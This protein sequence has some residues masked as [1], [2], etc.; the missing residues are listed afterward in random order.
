M[1][2]DTPTPEEAKASADAA[3][4]EAKAREKTL[5]A[6]IAAVALEK[7][8]T[9]EIRARLLALDEAADR[10]GKDKETQFTASARAREAAGLNQKL[11]EQE[12]ATLQK[13]MKIGAKMSQQEQSRYKL[14]KK[15]LANQAT[16][17][18]K[19]NSLIEGAGNLMEDK[20][21]GAVHIVAK[22]MESTLSDKF[23]MLSNSVS[24]LADKGFAK[25][26]TAA[27]DLIFQFDEVTKGF[28][29]QM[30][31]GAEYTNQI[32]S[33][34]KALNDYG[35]SLADAAEAQTQLATQFTDFTMLSISQREE[36]SANSAVLGQ[37]G[38]AQQD[39]ARGVQNSTKFFGQS[40]SAAVVT[41][42]ELMET[43]RA[44]GRSPAELSAEFAAAGSSLAKFGEQGVQAFKDL[45]RISKITGMEMNKVLSITNKFDTFEGAA[46][47]AGK[48]N[49]AM[50]GNMVNAM[51]MMMETDPAA[52][53]ETLRESIL[54]TV[55]SFDDMSYYQKQFYAESLGL[56]DVGD[57]AM[58][59]SGNM[60]SLAGATNQ[61]AAS[62][63]EEKENALQ[64]KTAKENLTI[65]MAKLAETFLPLVDS[66][67]KFASYLAQNEKLVRTLVI[68]LGLWK[69]VAIA[70][71]T[72]RAIR[73]AMAGPEA[74]A[75]TALA[76][77]ITL[78]ASATSALAAA[79]TAEGIAAAGSVPPLIAQ[80]GATG[81]AGTAATGA[82]GPFAAFALAAIQLGLATLA[83]GALAT[84]AYFAGPALSVMAVGI[85]ALG[86]AGLASAP[87]L[88]V[89]AAFAIAMAAS[90]FVAAA[91]VALMAA[92]M[93][94][95]FSQIDIPK[96]IAFG[97]LVGLLAFAAPGLL[98]A[99]AGFAGVGAGMLLF[100]LALKM[101]STRDLEAMGAF[102]TG[103]SE[104]N[105]G[106]INALVTA[107]RA[108][109]DAMDE[110]PTAKAILLTATLDAAAIAAKASNA[111][112][113][114][115]SG[116]EASRSTPSAQRQK[117]TPVNV[118]VTL[119]LDGEVLDRRIVKTSSD[120]RSSGGPLDAIANI[121]G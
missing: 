118:H 32:E 73:M 8:T 68:A 96:A 80:A 63:I 41:Q 23:S 117:N 28:E 38:V 114:R 7:E 31:L 30:Q 58:M 115:D 104:M 119:E 54:N 39:F 62:L 13:A 61:S 59:L 93:G 99:G 89:V 4:R 15:E 55:G 9:A 16:A 116:Q 18:N 37:L 46:E 19:V 43:A 2:T 67:Q 53:F 81:T 120:A 95:M 105:V 94:Y 24:G 69:I 70:L 49:A 74:A 64:L 50:G 78:Q 103:M 35:V 65:T 101:I 52:R 75:N 40:S 10:R 56:S 27:I 88:L 33:Q 84:A 107:L 112:A 26:K 110:I 1:P 102:A 108:V 76:A 5:D 91:G 34:Y 11:L 17:M 44:L 100:G 48:L 14:L 79:M 20:V 66:M 29:K 3:E 6:L 45:A 97:V 36:L 85:G 22:I 47:Q 82:T 98:L 92:G 25:L 72:Q 113:G 60:D 87:G 12:L 90:I 86:V 21:G 71:A 109:A 83:A 42:R 51:D 106:S 121:L 57:L 111:I 77:S